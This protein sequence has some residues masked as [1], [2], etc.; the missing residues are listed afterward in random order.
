MALSAPRRVLRMDFRGDEQPKQRCWRDLRG[1]RWWSPRLGSS[2]SPGLLGFAGAMTASPRSAAFRPNFWQVMPRTLHPHDAVK[3][4]VHLPFQLP[5]ASCR[6]PGGIYFP[7]L[8]GGDDG[9]MSPPVRTTWRPYRKRMV[10]MGTLGWPTRVLQQTT[11]AHDLRIM[12][13]PGDLQ[14]LGG[15]ECTPASAVYVVNSDE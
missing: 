13:D 9:T 12:H 7:L 5:F 4:L 8:F 1:P 14:V 10:W 15:N 2:A 11:V 3:S 6:P